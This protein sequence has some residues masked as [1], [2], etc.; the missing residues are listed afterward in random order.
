MNTKTCFVL[1]AGVLVALVLS[2]PAVLADANVANGSHRREVV[3]ALELA[4]RSRDRLL[5]ATFH[6]NLQAMSD[7]DSCA[8]AATDIL[9][10]SITYPGVVDSLT[11][12]EVRDW[13][14]IALEGKRYDWLSAILDETG[15]A[16]PPPGSLDRGRQALTA[17]IA[18]VT[19]LERDPEDEAA[20]VGEATLLD[21]AR[22]ALTAAAEEDFLLRD[23]AFYRLWDLAVGEGDT[24]AAVAWADSLIE[25]YPRSLRAPFVRISRVRDLVNRGLPGEAREEARLAL[26]L[27]DSADLRW[28]MIRASLDLGFIRQAAGE[29]EHLLTTFPGDP[30]A[31]TAWTERQAL[32]GVDSTLKLS[33]EKTV[34]L[35]TPLLGNSESG[36][37]E[38]MDTMASDETLEPDV[39][40]SAGITL[41]RYR[42]R[43]K[44]YTA[45]EPLL[46]RLLEAGDPDIA[47]EARIIQARIQRNTGRLEPMARNYRI[48]GDGDGKLA[49]RAT[50][51][52]GRE[53]ESQSRWSEA[54]KIYTTYLDRFTGG[55]RARDVRFRR[56]FDRY[57]Q[58][59]YTGAAEDFQTALTLSRSEADEEQ[60]AFWLALSLENQGKKKEARAA[61]AGGL[62]HPEPNDGYGVL[63]RRRYGEARPHPEAPADSTGSLDLGL[64]DIVDP[65]EWPGPVE[66]HFLRG[67]ELVTLGE[68]D[69]AR[70]EWTRASEL[71]RSYPSLIQS[72][73]LA[74]AAY[75]VYPEGVRWAIRSRQLLPE[76]H[77]D[78]EGYRRLAY[79]AAYYSHV[80]REAKRNLLSPWPLWALMRQE[81]LYDRLAV[82][83]AGA[84]GLMQIM[85]STLQQMRTEAGLPGL[86]AESLFSPRVNVTYGTRYFA[87]RLL[88]FDYQLLPTLASYNA[89]ERKSWE[90]LERADNN[91]EEVFIEC[92]G[93]PETYDYVRRILWLNWLYEE[94][95]GARSAI[96][97][98]DAGSR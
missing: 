17:G 59:N 98:A 93:Y 33:P 30:L 20:L 81:S 7:A 86:P 22:R 77:P 50:W 83:R 63:L 71:G 37:L 69:A 13:L 91:A 2:G 39:R 16:V 72:L 95:Y 57:R 23:E 27:G 80:T 96:S 58:K 8:E 67:I 48:L 15:G 6:G 74:A 97:P 31:V 65:S 53:M 41:C 92:I 35:L 56:G 32:A 47:D 4:A 25:G 88:E 45:A 51:E 3:D 64:F 60:A 82:S 87:D 79:P 38:L 14:C 44:S 66:W 94:Y 40:E 18:A 89:G 29:M 5:M 75:N 90:W 9:A 36:A 11:P 34:E 78:Q 55:Q 24:V 54:E 61:A 84:L 62:A 49:S 73:A 46:T 28:L 19:L 85:P 21:V 12:P 10:R 43:I 70:R 1:T 76:T 68:V 52:W 42:Y 26:P